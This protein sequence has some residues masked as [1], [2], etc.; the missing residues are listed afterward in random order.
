M[1]G[2]LRNVTEMPWA[3]Q[4]IPEGS[5][6]PDIEAPFIRKVALGVFLAVVS[7]VFFLFFVAY[8]ERMELA[9]WYPLHEPTILWFNTF[10]LVGASVAMQMARSTARG[11]EGSLQLR[12][13]M[14]G[15]L[16]IAF[17][18]GQWLAWNALRVGGYYATTNPANAFFFLLTALH[19][20]HLAGGLFVWARTMMRSRQGGAEVRVRRSIELC[21]L[22]WHYLLLL[23]LV[24]F[25]LMLN[26]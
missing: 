20:V 19:A 15:V 3:Q 7:S 4:G 23:W 16:V 26:T 17:L 2:W 10:L 18:G 8:L 11:A 5:E 1:P 13:L 12:L 24:L 6:A 25:A 22:Y 14:A 21:S 9:D